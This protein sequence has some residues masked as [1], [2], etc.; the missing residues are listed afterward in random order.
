M[1]R[2]RQGVVISPTDSVARSQGTLASLPL[3]VRSWRQKRNRS[4]STQ[5]G[6]KMLW[7]RSAQKV[8]LVPVGG[9]HSYKSG[10]MA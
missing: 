8:W 2:D 6:P 5:P 9:C 3:A 4:A 10:P 7:P 1:A